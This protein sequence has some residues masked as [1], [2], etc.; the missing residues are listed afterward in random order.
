MTETQ[1]ESTFVHF[2][3]AGILLAALIVVPGTAVCWN[4]IPKDFFQNHDAIEISQELSEVRKF[5]QNADHGEF[6][7]MESVAETVAPS[8]VPD[9]LMTLP[10]VAPPA[11]EIQEGPIKRMAGLNDDSENR[12][13]GSSFLQTN[14]AWPMQSVPAPMQRAEISPKTARLPSPLPESS[15]HSFSELENR[16]KQLGAK[17]YRL[18]KWGSNGE[19]YRFSCYVT[20][21]GTQQYQKH[22]QAIDSDELRVMESVIRD[23]EHWKR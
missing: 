17:Y 5:E 20:P 2:L 11:H 16:L 8:P 23:I 7:N 19:L 10:D 4:L 22:F 9:S 15:R 18:E 6:M 1:H 14:A 12:L 3:R 21:S 13:I